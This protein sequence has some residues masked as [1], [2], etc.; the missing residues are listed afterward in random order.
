MGNTFINI[1]RKYYNWVNSKGGVYIMG[2][3]I[4]VASVRR[5]C[6][7]LVGEISDDDVED[8]IT[9]VEAQIPRFFNT[10]YT[11]T[12]RIDIL[13]GDGTNRLLLDKN[14]VLSVRALKIDGTTEDVAN[15]D[16]YKDSGYIFLNEDAT[17]AIFTDQKNAIVVKYLY[18]TV[19]L[20]STTTSTSA[21]EVAGTSVSVVVADGSSFAENDWVEI[22]GMDGNRETAQISSISLNTL[23]IDQLVLAHEASSTVTKIEINETFVKLMNIVASIALVARIVGQSYTDIVGYTLA[24]MHV[25]KGEPYTQW[26]ETANQLIKE[27]DDIMKRISIR[28][29]VM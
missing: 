3:Y 28:P 24:E 19:D 1:G 8:T 5:S 10:F 15:L 29:R 27:R 6:G 14:P 12:E 21:A 20:S 23:T 7:I 11:P 17:T 13:N 4:T 25:Q 9:E 22:S 26:R 16:V 18:G 2:T